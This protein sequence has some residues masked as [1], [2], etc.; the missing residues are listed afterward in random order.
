MKNLDWSHCWTEVREVV[1]EDAGRGRRQRAGGPASSGNP[2]PFG[3][4]CRRHL[5]SEKVQVIIHLSFNAN[6]WK[7][8]YLAM[9]WKN[10]RKSESRKKRQINKYSLLLSWKYVFQF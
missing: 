9:I 7:F 5:R 2:T 6:W 8:V 3:R 4:D 10:G 1:E